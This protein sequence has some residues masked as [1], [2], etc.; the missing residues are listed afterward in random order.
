MQLAAGGFLLL[1][2]KSVEVLAAREPFFLAA[3]VHVVNR[4]LA[5]GVLPLRVRAKADAAP[6]QR[7]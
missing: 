5:G 2:D 1:G 7:H 4:E 3:E 6:L